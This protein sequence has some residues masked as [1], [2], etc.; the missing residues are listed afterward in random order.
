MRTSGIQGAVAK[1]QETCSVFLECLSGAP[2]DS[3]TWRQLAKHII[4]AQ[5]H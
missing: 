1:Q 4:R 3:G 5:I 2:A